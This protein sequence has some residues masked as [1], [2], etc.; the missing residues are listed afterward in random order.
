MRSLLWGKT[1]F[2]GAKVVINLLKCKQTSNF[3]SQINIFCEMTYRDL[4]YFLAE[5]L[6]ELYDWGSIDS[7]R[8]RCHNA[9]SLIMELR[10]VTDGWVKGNIID[11]NRVVLCANETIEEVKKDVALDFL[12]YDKDLFIDDIKSL[13]SSD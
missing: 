11:F 6:V 9:L 7:Y 3:L 12:Y 2:L 13:A 5:R 4:S 8:V 1:C 10:D